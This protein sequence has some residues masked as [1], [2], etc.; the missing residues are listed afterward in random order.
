MTKGICNGAVPYNSS[1]WEHCTIPDFP[2]QE[3]GYVIFLHSFH[4][5]WLLL[6]DFKEEICTFVPVYGLVFHIRQHPTLCCADSSFP[7]LPYSM[8]LSHSLFLCWPPLHLLF[9]LIQ[10]KFQEK[11]AEDNKWRQ[12]K[13]KLWT[14][15][16]DILRQQWRE[17]QIQRQKKK[18]YYVTC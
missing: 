2:L 5:P 10:K 11:E 6:S 3:W 16:L 18:T 1:V 9:F 4:Q 8:S 17:R 12:T 13:L 7:I 14:I 15:E